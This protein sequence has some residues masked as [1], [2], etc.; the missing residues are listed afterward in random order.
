MKVVPHVEAQGSAALR[1]IVTVPFLLSVD[2]EN[3]AVVRG[4]ILF[5]G[6]AAINQ[7]REK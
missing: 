2:P 5:Q 1:A 7:T 6:L 3:Q 4:V